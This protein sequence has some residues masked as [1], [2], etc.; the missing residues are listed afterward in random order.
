MDP[1]ILGGT[2]VIAGTRIPV[3]R[4]SSLVRHG[5]T[6]SALKEEYP[7]VDVEKIQYIISYLMEEGLDVFKKT[8]KI[9]ATS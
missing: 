4:V 7:H 3:E 8:Y 2:P 9:Q 1:D 5:Y 6:A